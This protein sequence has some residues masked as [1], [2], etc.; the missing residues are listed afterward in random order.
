KPLGVLN[1]I[2]TASSNPGDVVMDFFAGSGTTGLA[3]HQLG[4]SFIL[5][6]RS[7]DALRVMANRFNG[8]ADVRY[9]GYQP[10]SLQLTLEIE[11]STQNTL[12]LT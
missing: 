3:A 9:V 11:P 1:R 6:D 4:R 7:E 10:E 8:V 2:V 5:I 12:E